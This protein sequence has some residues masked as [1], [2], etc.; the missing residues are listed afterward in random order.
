MITEQQ[1]ADIDG[2]LRELYAQGQTKFGPDR[3]TEL[4]AIGQAPE[5]P[6]EA[7]DP[8]SLMEMMWW[9]DV[10]GIVADEAS[11]PVL[12]FYVRVNDAVTKSGV[13]GPEQLPPDVRAP[14]EAE[15][16]LAL[17]IREAMA[18]FGFEL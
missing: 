14:L 8:R 2:R 15:A 9:R 13:Q 18:L 5:T 16:H 3:V 7:T 6:D 10:L 1:A 12:D 4:V 17:R 11:P